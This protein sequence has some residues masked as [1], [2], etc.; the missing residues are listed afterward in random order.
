[1]KKLSLIF[2]ALICVF[3]VNAEEGSKIVIDTKDF[4][5]GGG[6]GLNSLSGIELDDG[7]GLQVFAGYELPLN[8]D[9]GAL[10]IQVGYMDSGNV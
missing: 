6:L 7:L 1:M 8:M 9:K 10:S 5:F 4:Y 2:A 3:N